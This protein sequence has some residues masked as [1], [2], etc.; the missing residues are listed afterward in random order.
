MLNQ[1]QKQLFLKRLFDFLKIESISAD[2][3][4]KTEIT[5]A[6]SFLEEELLEIGFKKVEKLYAKK[7]SQKNANPVVY[8]E[9][10]GR[11]VK[12]TL[13]IYGH[14][15]IQPADPI[16]EWDSDPF[17]PEIRNNKIYARGATDDKGQ[18]YTHL[19]ALRILAKEWGEEW[20]INVKIAIEGEEETSGKN[21]ENLIKEKTRKFKA[22]ICLISDS[23]FK[24]KGKPSLEVSLRGIVYGELKI[25]VAK[26]DLHSGI[27]GGA[28]NN[29]INLLAQI[30]TEL[31]KKLSGAKIRKEPL[32]S[33]YRSFDVHGIKGGY[34]G[35]GAKTVIPGGASGK[36]SLRIIPGEEPKKISS[37]IK[38]EIKKMMPK[39]VSYKLDFLGLGEPYAVPNNGR[40]LRFASQSLEKV[41]GKKPSFEKSGGSIPVVSIIGKYL[42]A[43]VILMG[44]G[45]P[46]D[47]LHS[48]N[49]KLDLEQFYKGIECNID[50]LRRLSQDK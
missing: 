11:G 22:D 49:E 21:L 47:N 37:L 10:I 25:R 34:T 46:D 27:F 3:K 4:Y 40:F 17:K 26:Q 44:Y 18:L 20:P 43:E 15:D 38:K 2:S 16:S 45:L 19:G 5:R 1:N 42:K 50:F 35:L 9:K 31:N 39:N 14:Y 8:A 36:F 12:P 23:G 6:V 7:L 32:N 33:S 48:P 30:F 41:F 13:L 28:I 29:P 24:A